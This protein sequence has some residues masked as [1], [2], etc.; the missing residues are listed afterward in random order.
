MRY[1]ALD[2]GKIVIRI[3]IYSFD[4]MSFPL[5]TLTVNLETEY[6]N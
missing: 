5:T 3:R 2:F 1:L 6:I 4:C